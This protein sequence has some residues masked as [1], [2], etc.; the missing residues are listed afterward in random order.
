MDF[1]LEEKVMGTVGV[2]E[3][4]KYSTSQEHQSAKR[5]SSEAVNYPMICKHFSLDEEK[6]DTMCPH[7]HVGLDLPSRR[8]MRARRV[9]DK[10][11]NDLLEH[12][13]NIYPTSRRT[14][15]AG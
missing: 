3:L 8:S 9:D 11:D 7:R 12:S 10:R 13:N 1:D 6:G 5:E 2:K 15:I 4:S 14:R